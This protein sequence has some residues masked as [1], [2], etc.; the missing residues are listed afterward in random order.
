MQDVRQVIV[1]Q[2]V[3]LRNAKWNRDLALKSHGSSRGGIYISYVYGRPG[4]PAL[5]ARAGG[6][7]ESASKSGSKAE[8]L[9]LFVQDLLF[10]RRPNPRTRRPIVLMDNPYFS[11]RCN[12][13]L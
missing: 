8:L 2:H 7:E 3:I 11:L 5:V 6:A 1:V 9:L 13:Y 10:A 4:P 12:H